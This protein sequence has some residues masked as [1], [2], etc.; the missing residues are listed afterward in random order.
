[1]NRELWSAA[2][3]LYLEATSHP[4]GPEA[5]LRQ[6]KNVNDE[7]VALVRR[8]LSQ[9]QQLAPDLHHP[10]WVPDQ[11]GLPFRS[12]E[13]GRMLLDRFEIVGFL[14]AGGL[15]EVYRAFDHRQLV[16]VALKTL[17]PELAR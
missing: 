1:M 7:V 6:L 11:E 5:C 15:G 3:S 9:D 4:D 14:G 12:L 16:F 10:C 2:K 8:L 17:R 13:I